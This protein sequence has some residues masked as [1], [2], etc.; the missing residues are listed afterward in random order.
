MNPAKKMHFF[1]IFVFFRA[2]VDLELP[3]SFVRRL[4]KFQR[5]IRHV[6]SKRALYHLF[7][8]ETYAGLFEME[9]GDGDE[10]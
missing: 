9:S 3:L 8:V 6:P 1:W 2:N 5:G 7:S 10:E 4:A